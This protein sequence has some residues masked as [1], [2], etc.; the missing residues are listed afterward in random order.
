MGEV[1]RFLTCMRCGTERHDAFIGGEI[2]RR[3]AYPAGYAIAGRIDVTELRFALRDRA[4]L[5][6]TV[7]ALREIDLR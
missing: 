3:Y 1:R 5:A 7:D 2:R 6:R 4:R